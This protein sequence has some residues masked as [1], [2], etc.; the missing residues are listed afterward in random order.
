[1]SQSPL[2]VGI[3]G[4]GSHG[5]N[6]V[7]LL[8]EMGHE[9]FGVDADPEVR[10]EFQWAFDA[11]TYENPVDLYENDI[12]AAI[13]STPNK[14]HEGAAVDALE[15]GLDVMLEKPLAH[16]LD[17]AEQI[18]SVAKS[19]ENVCMI[20]YHHR[21]RNICQVTKS[22][23]ENGYLGDL[24]HVRARYIRRRGVPGR[25]TWF[26]SEDIAGGGALMDIGAHLID[27]L[28]YLGGWPE[29]SD[30]MAVSRSDFGQHEDYSYLHMW[31]EDDQGRMYDVEDS[32]TAFCEFKNGLTA[33]IEV[34]WAANDV[35][36]HSYMIR[37][38]EAGAKL[39][40][41]NSLNEVDP[42]VDQRNELE[43]YEARS[44]GS[45]HFVNSDVVAP[46]NDPYRAE[47]ETFLTAV[48]TGERP[49]QNNVD[50]A[51]QVQ[52]VIDD[53]YAASE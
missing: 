28:L 16:N 11:D 15:N 43:L 45:D 9:V 37:G 17:S 22:Y 21:Y 30:V 52:R 6:H 26:T 2:K 19:T 18:A 23:I 40:I 29:L 35:S 49:E 27:M 24:T 8:T 50:Q 12:D 44:G 41:T 47:L 51:L 33:S 25:G 53:I 14:F 48:R 10:R 36:K 38:T 46:L 1:M 7:E 13:I 3:I 34:A 31:G 39:N 20:G 4:L 5:K 32:V 42:L